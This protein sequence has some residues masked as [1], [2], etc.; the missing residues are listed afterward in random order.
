MRLTSIK[1]YRPGIYLTV[2][3]TIKRFTGRAPEIV[4]ISTKPILEGF[5]IWLLGNQGYVLN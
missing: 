4:N 2:N 5:K 1:Y 3:E